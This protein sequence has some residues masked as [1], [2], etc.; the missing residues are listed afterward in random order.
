MGTI[1]EP[2]MRWPQEGICEFLF[3]KPSVDPVKLFDDIVDIFKDYI[4]FDKDEI[5][6]LLALWIMGTYLF[7]LFPAYPFF[8]LNGPFASGKSRT[9]KL[10][11][12]LCFNSCLLTSP[13]EAVIYRYVD[14]YRSSLFFDNAEWLSRTKYT[15]LT[16]TLNSS[17]KKG[18]KVPRLAGSKKGPPTEFEIYSPKMFNNTTGA[19]TVLASRSIIVNQIRAS[20][21]VKIKKNEPTGE[22]PIW[23]DLRNR[24]YLF[25]FRY[26]K[27]VERLIPKQNIAEIAGRDHELFVGILS[28]AQ[29]LD[30][31]AG[32]KK[33]HK[34][35]LDFAIKQADERKNEYLAHH[36]EALVMQAL[37]SIVEKDG[38]YSVY[39][40]SKELQKYHLKDEKITDAWVGRIL[41]GMEIG[42]T[43]GTWKRA[44]EVVKKQ[45]KKLTQYKI[46][47]QQVQ[48]LARKYGIPEAL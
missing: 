8:L 5:Y 31:L 10:A 16:D 33:L 1:P 7:P 37:L 26:W 23:E 46:T 48:K 38:W 41:N 2:L 18:T 30:K 21:S 27:Q 6:P 45:E 42:K 44:V 36:P 25:M 12:Y 15:R 47:R 4:Y 34:T 20:K 14:T 13:N 19:E 40:I 22:E 32:S 24:L 28:I 43:R 35:I 11:S 29:L 3:D 39:K 9:T 17:Y